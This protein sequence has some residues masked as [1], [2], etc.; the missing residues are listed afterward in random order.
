MS[1]SV[2]NEQKTANVECVSDKPKFVSLSGKERRQKQLRESKRRRRS[3]YFVDES[4][5]GSVNN[6]TARLEKL[7]Q[8]NMSAWDNKSQ[9]EKL[10]IS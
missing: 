7:K 5:I 2:A 6:Q 8:R 4:D 1:E 3:P 10:H 9:E